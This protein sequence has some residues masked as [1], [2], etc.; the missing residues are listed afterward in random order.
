MWVGLINAEIRWVEPD[1][2]EVFSSGE[3]EGPGF[4]GEALALL[5]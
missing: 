4:R 5:Q 3:M 1:L 2:E